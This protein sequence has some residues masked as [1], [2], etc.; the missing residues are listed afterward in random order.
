MLLN[1]V[2]ILF[3]TTLVVFPIAPSCAGPGNL[4]PLKMA[5]RD[6]DLHIR[7][8]GGLLLLPDPVFSGC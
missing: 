5:T 3:P 8:S 2:L 6:P 4:N 1:S 7:L